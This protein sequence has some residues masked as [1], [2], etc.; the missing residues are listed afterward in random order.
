ML[1]YPKTNNSTT[2]DNICLKLNLKA[3]SYHFEQTTANP[4]EAF[5]IKIRPSYM[6]CVCAKD[7]LY[8]EKTE[9]DKG[10]A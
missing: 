8:S 5:L 3:K 9:L 1:L 10:W 2:S 6:P 7:F 4:T